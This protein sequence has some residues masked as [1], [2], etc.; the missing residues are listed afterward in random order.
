VLAHPFEVKLHSFANEFFHLIES[1]H[2]AE[3][4]KI[5]STGALGDFS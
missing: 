1:A 5:G 3:A 2:N 4:W